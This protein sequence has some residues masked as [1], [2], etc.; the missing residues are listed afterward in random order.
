MNYA[1]MLAQNPELSLEEIILLDKVQ[2][3]KPCS[4]EELKLLRAK[5]LIEGRNPNIMISAQVAQLT[6]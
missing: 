4:N 6:G 3:R 2:K 1:R 5:K